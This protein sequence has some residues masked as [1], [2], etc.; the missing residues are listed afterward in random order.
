MPTVKRRFLLPAATASA[1]IAMSGC[2]AEVDDESSDTRLVT[3]NRCG[4]EV[5]YRDPKRVVAYEAGSADK[6][7]ELGLDDRMLGYVMAPTN[8]DPRTSPYAD[9][10]AKTEL[11][12]EDLLNKELVVEQKADLV[13][14]GWNSGF[15]EERG[16]T[17][18]ILDR[19]GIQSFMHTETCFDYP[20]HPEKKKP[21]EA[22]YTDFERLGEI[23]GVEDRAAQVVDDLSSRMESVAAAGAESGSEPAV[24]LYDSGTDQASTVGSQ[25]PANEIIEA[26]GGR[27]IFADVNERYTSVGWE[28]VVDESPEIIM[29]MNYRD[30]PADEKIADLKS[31]PALKEVPA[32]KN[33][34][35]YVIDY[36]E[37]ISGPRNVDGAEKFQKWLSEN[38]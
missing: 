3:V 29:I 16:I 15:S 38:T 27:N 9:N 28:S 12:S 32:V 25:V 20:G 36:N 23:F 5:E 30:K 2:G 17:P 18:E 35:F 34:N 11:L 37:C 4:E 13:V 22:L 14:A 24:F 26:A 7:F 31:N 1:V 10:Y 8:P 6:L 33:D 19:L 21:F